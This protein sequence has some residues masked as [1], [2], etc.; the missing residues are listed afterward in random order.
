MKLKQARDGLTQERFDTVFEPTDEPL[1][2]EL[3]SEMEGNTKSRR[4][5]IQSARSPALSGSSPA[6]VDGPATT[7]SQA[8]RHMPRALEKF[9]AIE[10]GVALAKR[11]PHNA[12]PRRSWE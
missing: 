1:L 8:P 7:A 5:P 9:A 4:I 10:R 11:M 12:I 3:S 2:E 6:S